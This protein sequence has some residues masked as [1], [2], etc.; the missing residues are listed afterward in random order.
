MINSGLYM[1]NIWIIYGSS[2]NNLWLMIIMGYE[3][4]IMGNISFNG[5]STGIMG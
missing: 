1:V 3:L 2:M 4:L 5:I